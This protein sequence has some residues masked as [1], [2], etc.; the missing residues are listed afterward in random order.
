[1]ALIQARSKIWQLVLSWN[2][3]AKTEEIWGAILVFYVAG[4]VI[5]I[6]ICLRLFWQWKKKKANFTSIT[7]YLLRSISSFLILYSIRKHQ[8][9]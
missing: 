5:F 6:F 3:Y 7:F 2:I 1:M 8:K 9:S 4:I